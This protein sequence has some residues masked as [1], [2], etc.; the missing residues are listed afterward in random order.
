MFHPR[1]CKAFAI[2]KSPTSVAI[3]NFIAVNQSGVI[4]FEELFYN[5]PRYMDEY[6]RDYNF[7][8]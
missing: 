6:G 4:E 5:Q 8:M 3:R 1:D 7:S 2:E